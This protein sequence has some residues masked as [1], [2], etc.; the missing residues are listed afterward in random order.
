[1]KLPI[2][3]L[4]V[5]VAAGFAAGQSRAA[6]P[7]DPAARIDAREPRLPIT[8][9]RDFI[10]KAAPGAEAAKLLSWDL[11]LGATYTTN[12]GQSHSGRIETGYVTPGLAVTLNPQPLGGAWLFGG[13]LAYDGDYFGGGHDDLAESRLKGAAYLKRPLGQD[14]KDGVVGLNFTALGSYTDDFADRNYSL[15]VYGLSYSRQ[16]NDRLAFKLTGEHHASGLAALRRV[17]YGG[18]VSYDTGQAWLGHDIGLFG[19]ALA[20]NFSSGPND[21]RRDVQVQAGLT[22]THALSDAVALEWDLVFTHRFSNREASR[23]DEVDFGPAL[24]VS[25]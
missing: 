5:T 21:G 23:F 11:S 6:E 24:K 13:S 12:A 9:S 14:G 18:A 16:V 3:V 22:A 8:P 25:F 17:R 15:Q 19:S 4:S 2:L 10:L 7:F 1:M 20:S